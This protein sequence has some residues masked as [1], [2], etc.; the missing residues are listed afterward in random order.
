MTSKKTY[1][2]NVRKFDNAGMDQLAEIDELPNTANRPRFDAG[3]REAVRIYAEDTRKPNINAVHDEIA[4]LR[5]AA[6]RRVYERVARLIEALSLGVRERFEMRAATPG[7]INAGLRFP[8]ANALRDPARQGEACDIVRRFCTMG[9]KY[10][11]GRKRGSGKRSTT[12]APLPWAPERIS[13][14]PK[15]Q[16]ERRCVMHLRL[17]QLEATGTAASATVNPLRPGPFARFVGECLKRAG[18]PHADPVGLNNE[19]NRRRR[20]LSRFPTEEEMQLMQWEDDGG[21]G[22]GFPD[23]IVSVVESHSD[24]RA[25]WRHGS[26]DRMGVT[27]FRGTAV[28]LSIRCA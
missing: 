9:G 21:C 8:A 3:V 20:I 24:L 4:R 26:A 13:H 7:F 11:E 6:S 28:R 25:D 23:Q 1:P 12:W 15:R 18:A 22:V 17:A 2:S 5:Q 19:L 16:A 10:I 14:P 27:C